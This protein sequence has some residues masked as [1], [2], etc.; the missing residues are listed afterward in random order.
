MDRST[1]AFWAG[2]GAAEIAP[3]VRRLRELVLASA[4][5]FADETTVPILNPGRGRTKT[6]WF[7]T[8]ARDDR[9]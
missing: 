1:L 8:V 9:S 6:G 2:Y 7:W 5:I 3:V 4:R